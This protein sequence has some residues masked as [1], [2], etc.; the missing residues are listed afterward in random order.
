MAREAKMRAVVRGAVGHARHDYVGEEEAEY[1]GGGEESSSGEEK[2][3]EVVPPLKL[4]GKAEPKASSKKAGAKKALPAWAKTESKATEEEEEEELEEADD[5]MDFV[6]GLNFD[7][8]DEDLELKVLMDKV[9]ERISDLE[10][11]KDID[12]ETLQK[13]IDR[14]MEMMEKEEAGEDMGEDMGGEDGEGERSEEKMI[15]EVALT[16]RS[17]MKEVHSTKSLEALV[18]Q[19]TAFKEN[20]SSPSLLPPLIEDAPV[21]MESSLAAPKIITHTIDNGSAIRDK[22][23]NPSK[24][25]YLNRNPAV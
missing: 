13:L 17:D 5:L 8:Y 24:L 25:P 14:E 1:A 4:A 20:S 23:N 9:K 18:R 16:A 10:G 15:K 7:K 6:D 21:D 22:K 11:E 3:E 12:E 19:R 2:K